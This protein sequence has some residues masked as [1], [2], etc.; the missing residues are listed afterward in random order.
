MILFEMK[1]GKVASWKGLNFKVLQ[2]NV[3]GM[4]LALILQKNV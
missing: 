3:R 4:I 1:L 2:S